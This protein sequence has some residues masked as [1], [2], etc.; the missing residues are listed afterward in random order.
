M[1]SAPTLGPAC[2]RTTPCRRP[3]LA[4]SQAW[5]GRIVGLA[6][7]CCRSGPIVSQAPPTVSLRPRARW[8]AV[9]QA[10]CCV[11]CRAPSGPYRGAS[12]G[13]VALV[14]QYNPAGKPRAYHD[15]PIRIATQ[16]PSSQALARA[17]L[18]LRVSRPYRG[19]SRPYSGRVPSRIMALTACPCAPTARPVSRYNALYHDQVQNGQKHSQLP[20]LFFFSHH[21]FSHSS[22]WKTTKKKKNF[23]FQ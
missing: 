10:V 17:P 11:P 1:H 18:S 22:Y 15:T 3:G 4:I 13:R 2:A 14:S 20:E 9:S 21:F 16:A 19:L 7:P 8:R 23:I 6:G 5:P 12:L